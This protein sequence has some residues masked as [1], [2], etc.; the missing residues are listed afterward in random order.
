MT[1]YENFKKTFNSFKKTQK[2]IDK[3]KN[4]NNKLWKCIEKKGDIYN[5]GNDYYY[6][7][8]CIK[9]LNKSFI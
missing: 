4:L 2:K 8:N 1:E 9:T 5:C 7:I 6:F 3:C